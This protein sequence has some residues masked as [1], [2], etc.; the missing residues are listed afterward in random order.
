[1]ACT[2][3][4]GG[5]TYNESDLD[6]LYKSVRAYVNATTK[7]LETIEIEM[8]D[9]KV[10]KILAGTKTTILRTERQGKQIGLPTGQSAY[11]MIG[12]TP[13]V[14]TNRGLL[15]INEAGGQ[16]A[17]LKSEDIASVDN[18]VFDYSKNW[19]LGKGKVY[20]YDIT[21]LPKSEQD[22]DDTSGLPKLQQAVVKGNQVFPGVYNI[23]NSGLTVEQANGFIDLLQPQIEGQAYVENKA[24]TANYMFSFGLRWARSIPN[25]GEKSKQGE[26]LGQP[27]PN[28]K[29]IKSKEAGT[30]GYFTTDQNNNPLPPITDLSPIISFIESKLGI[31]LS[32][33]DAMLGNIYD[34]KSFIHQHRDTTESVTAEKYPVV[35]INLG[36][37]G[38]LEYDQDTTST[39]AKYQKSGQLDL[40]NGGI[41][42]FGVD[43]KNRFTFHHRIGQ[44]LES[45]N[46]L[47]PIT[48]PDG[49]VL[50]DYRITL[51]F[52]RAADLDKGMPE[53]PKKLGKRINTPT[54]P[55]T[56]KENP[57]LKAG[58]K[59]TDMKGNAAKDIEMA[60]QATQFIG[61]QAGNAKVS[62]TGKYRAAWGNKANTG[63]YTSN[64]VVMVSASGLFRGVT[65]ED[66]T[67]VLT[68]NYK[69]LLNEAISVG[70][71]F[72]VGNQYDK[73]NFGDQLI[74]EYLSRKGYN[75]TKF[76]GYSKWTVAKPQTIVAD[77]TPLK[78][79]KIRLENLGYTFTEV[80]GMFEVDHVNIP[81]SLDA[82][83]LEDAIKLAEADYNINTQDD[84]LGISEEETGPEVPLR[85]SLL[86]KLFES[87]GIDVEAITGKLDD[88]VNNFNEPKYKPLRDRLIDSPY[89]DESSITFLDIVNNPKLLKQNPD[90]IKAEPLEDAVYEEKQV[91][92]YGTEYTVYLQNGIPVKTDLKQG[93][94]Q[95]NEDYQK[96]NKAI[97]E[98]FKRVNQAKQLTLEDQINK[99]KEDVPV[100]DNPSKTLQ[101]EQ[102][103]A[104]EV[105]QSWLD[106]DIPMT[107]NEEEN[108]YN[109]AFFLSGPGGSGK[110]YI[111]EILLKG[112]NPAIA[113]P[114]HQARGVLS[115]NFPEIKAETVQS[116]FGMKPVPRKDNEFYSLT[117]KDIKSYVTSTNEKAAELAPNF[118]IEK[119]KPIFLID[120]A[121]MLGGHYEL[122]EAS[123]TVWEEDESGKARSKEKNVYIEPDLG[124]LLQKFADLYYQ[125]NGVHPKILLTGDIAQTPMVDTPRG[126]VSSI[127]QNLKDKGNYFELLKIR[128]TDNKGI[129][130]LSMGIRNQIIGAV[131]SNDLK[132]KNETLLRIL[133]VFRNTTLYSDEYQHSTVEGEFV[134]TF[135]KY[136][137]TNIEEKQDPEYTQMINFNAENNPWTLRMNTLIRKSLFGEKAAESLVEGEVIILTTPN[138]P[139][140]FVEAGQVTHIPLLKDT[141][142]FITK[143]EPLEKKYTHKNKKSGREVSV[144]VPGYELTANVYHP[145]KG[146]GNPIEVKFFVVDLSVRS[147]VAEAFQQLNENPEAFKVD[148]LGT[149]VSRKE[150]YIFSSQLPY[151]SFGYIVNNYKIQG[152]AVKN[153]FVHMQ[154]IYDAPA[155][156]DYLH[157]AQFLYTGVS[158]TREKLFTY[159][160]KLNFESL[161]GTR[162]VE[163][164]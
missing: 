14:I 155:S 64:D 50:K 75:E 63:N 105:I 112:R 125:L 148:F 57:L 83:T 33:Y 8:Q 56:L 94:E 89:F 80:D 17:I 23:K 149:Q 153:P 143:L 140:S 139:A 58:V 129:A 127:L 147:K 31:D 115:R 11:I 132:V 36:A 71:S 133:D 20:V 138:I 136:Y 1:M 111:S 123:I 114:T 121:S 24:K 37:D 32:D 39:Y 96:Q 141:K 12:D 21:P 128:R 162:P 108:F 44:G 3:I 145:D 90:T 99:G 47:K 19:F 137:K 16:D 65:T 76:D 53:S 85:D 126:A 124:T 46:L 10:S 122:E 92:Y 60:E 120:E 91:S 144:V 95:S 48:L 7:D 97:I 131:D 40:T 150:L 160:P 59:P 134:D 88:F 135:V 5:K 81:F 163:C 93:E 27:R 110:T 18:F 74:S 43:G 100:T 62:S 22:P 72:V 78:K 70:A 30:Y 29:A 102:V 119:S 118:F 98:F 68:E 26:A 152:S 104:Y 67:K 84:N 4:F 109:H 82:I 151:W 86:G 157:I 154:N 54:S 161:P 41:Y 159:H 2:Y 73:G 79:R 142:A 55:E 117:L 107:A 61:Y 38:H 87:I 66:I 101:D 13:F 35:V 42:A 103:T 6:L 25:A 116:L 77:D 106:S 28:K 51:T 9:D 158:R 156:K 52:R 164:Q 146:E 130:D 15:D 69:P 113:A 34:D 45:K 49:T